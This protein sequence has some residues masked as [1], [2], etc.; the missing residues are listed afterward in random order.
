MSNDP[1][2]FDGPFSGD[3]DVPPGYDAFGPHMDP[4]LFW[5]LVILAGVIVGVVLGVK[6]M[7]ER[8]GY[9]LLE[10]RRQASAEAIYASVKWHLDRALKA[11]GAAIL[12]RG[13][14]VGDVLES[15]LGLV[16]AL[17]NKPG[18]LIKGLDDAIAG[19]KA[20]PAG[21]AKVKVALATELHALEVRKALEELSLHWK[22]KPRIMAMILAAQLELGRVPKAAPAPGPALL[23]G[24]WPKK[25]E[26]AVAG[27]LDDANKAGQT[28]VAPPVVTPAPSPEPT[29]DTDPTPPAPAPKGRKLPA[30]KRNMLA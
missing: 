18:K 15:R 1:S 6:Y 27:A 25:V 8:R 10:R 12:E 30:H 3:T 20:G 14:E 28:A 26:K 16:L 4:A 11:S 17:T 9:L 7:A 23:S 13:R 21:P 22:D 2:D 29:P 19:K 24:L 5:G